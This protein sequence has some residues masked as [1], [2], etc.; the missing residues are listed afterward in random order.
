MALADAVEGARHIAQQ[1]TWTDEDGTVVDLSGSTL[2][3]VKRNT[4]T[5]AETALDGTLSFENDGSDGVFNWTYG[6][7]DVGT[8]G[9]FIVQFTA[10]YG[11]ND[12]ER[13]LHHKWIVYEALSV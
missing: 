5:G 2:T 12:L 1:I 6:E 9:R 7:T 4:D 11:A 13:T 10:T 3:G 8:S